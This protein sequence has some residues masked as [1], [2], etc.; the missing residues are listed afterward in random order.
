[1]RARPEVDDHA[2]DL[3]HIAHEARPRWHQWLTRGRSVKAAA[4]VDLSLAEVES[5]AESELL[6]NAAMLDTRSENA[7]AR[8]THACMFE[9]F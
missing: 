9:V 4:L 8:P 6:K 5:A 1:M 3:N 2:D 7:R